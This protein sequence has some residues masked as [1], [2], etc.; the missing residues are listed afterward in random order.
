MSMLTHYYTLSLHDALPIFPRALPW[1]VLLQPFRLTMPKRFPC[2]SG[3]KLDDSE[4]NGLSP[5]SCY[6]PPPMPRSEEH[7][8]ELQSPVHLECRFLFENKKNGFKLVYKT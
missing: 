8:S 3:L 6:A 5:E 4:T 1:A 2:R 7:T